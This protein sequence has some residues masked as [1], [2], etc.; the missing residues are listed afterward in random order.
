MN[1]WSRSIRRKPRSPHPARWQ[2]LVMPLEGRLA[3]G[4]ALLSAVFGVSL[5]ELAAPHA[6]PVAGLTRNAPV[7][8]PRIDD[9]AA[10]VIAVSAW[11]AG[12]AP[13]ESAC[14]LTPW[15]ASPRETEAPDRGTSGDFGQLAPTAGKPPAFWNGGTT[16]AAPPAAAVS[17]RASGP[18]SGKAPALAESA[19]TPAVGSP[20]RQPGLNWLPE[21]G[22]TTGHSPTDSHTPPPPG[23]MTLFSD[24]FEDGVAD[25]WTTYGGT[26]AVAADGSRV[27]RESGQSST[28]RAA[29]GAADWTDYVAEARVKPTG[30]N[31]SDRAV[32]LMGRFHDANNTYVLALRSSNKVELSKI[33]SGSKTSLAVKSFPVALNTWYTLKLEVNGATLRGYV[34]GL[35]QVAADD[36]TFAEGR[37]GFRTEY[38]S[39]NFDDVLV[40]TGGPPVNQPPQVS[41]GAGQVVVF[42]D[43]AQLDGQVTDDGLPDPPATVTC[44]WTQDAGPGDVTFDPG[45]DV[46]QPTASFSALGNYILRLTCSDSELEGSATV[47]ISVVDEQT[48]PDAP[49]GWASVDAWGQDGTTGGFGGPTVVAQTAAEFLDYI[50]RPGPYVI[51]VS[52]MLRLPGPMHNVASDKTIIGLGADSGI[53]GGGLN[54]GIPVNNTITQPPPDAI[55]NVIIRNLIFANL[56]DDAINVQMFSHHVWIDHC[57]LSRAYDGLIDIK[58]GS[59]Y[60]TVSWNHVHNHVKDMLLGHADNNGAQDIGRLKVTYHHNWFDGTPER[61]PRVRFG[62]PVHVFNNYYFH[63]TDVGVACQD[64]GGCLVEGN[65]FENVDEPM[66]IHY[67]GPAGRIVER[68]NVYVNSGRPVVGG[69]VEEPGLSY[70]YVLDNPED[71]KEIVTQGAGVG[72]IGV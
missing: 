52:G 16:P 72:K 43:A 46:L 37:V 2:P 48:P 22:R 15:S 42:P 18:S 63:N 57:D 68:Q 11:D 6:E 1:P 58:R 53:T 41:A 20:V 21:F 17:A 33:V 3:A 70:H 34:N 27:Y 30:W 7:Q 49:V 5:L 64:N 50:A 47:P 71:V 4:D 29:A 23:G 8:R 62:D 10:P 32:A 54:I 12:R 35:L 65:Y 55:K 14:S 28:Y 67:S 59:S 51:E 26:W 60:V 38:A 40:T 69:T 45:P 24:D 31:G 13:H 61:N 39:A 44:L 36:G 25:G 56:P 9:D 66:T 19:G